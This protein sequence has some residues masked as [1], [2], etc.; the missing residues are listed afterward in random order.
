MFKLIAIRKD[1]SYRLHLE[2]LTTVAEAETALKFAVG[3]D[4]I[5]DGFVL[6]ADEPIPVSDGRTYAQRVAD[7]HAAMTAFGLGIATDIRATA[8]RLTDPSAR[9]ERFA[10]A[11]QI[12]DEVR[13]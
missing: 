1:G 3:Q 11:D 10:I 5:V 8:L 9:L 12:V 6:S 13:R 7:F 2:N 4:G